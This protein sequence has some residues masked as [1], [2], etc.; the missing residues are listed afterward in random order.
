MASWHGELK[1]DIYIVALLKLTSIQPRQICKSKK[2]L[3]D[4]KQA[5]REFFVKLSS[6]LLSAGYTQFMNN[7]SMFINSTKGTF[8]SLSVYVDDIIL[9]KNDKEDIQDQRSWELRYFLGLEVPRS[10]KGIMLNQENM[11]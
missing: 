8:T 7:H 11:Y 4:L 9:A 6:F 2:A 1:E 10:D 5:N 3:C